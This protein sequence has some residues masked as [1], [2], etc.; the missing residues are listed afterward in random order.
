MERN[1]KEKDAEYLFAVS[2]L[3]VR[4]W[5]APP[6]LFSISG[7]KVLTFKISCNT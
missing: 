7:A 4:E 1:E 6:H 5:Q 2:T 3:S